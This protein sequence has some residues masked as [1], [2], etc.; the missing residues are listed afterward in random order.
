MPNCRFIFFSSL[1]ALLAHCLVLSPARCAYAE[2]LEDLNDLVDE[3][4]GRVDEVETR[5]LLDKLSLG[6][7]LRTKLEYFNRRHV[8]ATGESGD[9][10]DVWTNRFRVNARAEMGDDLVFHSRLSLFY[11]YN[12]FR[13]PSHYHF[14][15]SIKRKPDESGSLKVE[16]AYFDYFFPD[17]NF[18]ITL[19]RGPAG[20]GPPLEFRNDSSR[21]GTYPLVLLD[22][23]LDG[24]FL[25]YDSDDLLGLQD[26]MFRVVYAK[27][28]TNLEALNGSDLGDE[29]I[30]L[31]SY[32]MPIPG[33]E[34][35]Q[36]WLSYY[37]V[38]DFVVYDLPGADGTGDIGDFTVM[39]LHTQAMDI[40]DSGFDAFLSFN[41][42]RVY[43]RGPGIKFPAGTLAPI[44]V[45]LTLTGSSVDGSI[46]DTTDAYLLYSGIRYRIASDFFRNPKLGFE[47]HHATKFYHA[48]YGGEDLLNKLGIKGESYELYYLQ[49][50]SRHL[51]FRLGLLVVDERYYSPGLGIPQPSS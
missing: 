48:A 26:S 24:V 29:R 15:D 47:F 13:D 36:L 3:I 31:F 11:I 51:Y 6:A 4:E 9:T 20:D 7:E 41:W 45:S 46:D 23:T 33:V 19:G 25:N 16:R 27:F 21:K 8:K 42:A 12:E 28:K 18:S 17:S 37:R 34:R 39:T 50:F 35:T 30:V 44:D 22:G 40:A 10:G 14:I 2:S 1:C 32:E 43:N 38:F 5:T 49:P